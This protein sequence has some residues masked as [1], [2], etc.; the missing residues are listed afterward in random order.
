[1]RTLKTLVD[2]FLISNAD[3]DRSLLVILRGNHHNLTEYS[4]DRGE[5]TE[6]IMNEMGFVE[7]RHG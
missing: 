2:Q 1:V 3:A 5:R 6:R 4:H 7:R